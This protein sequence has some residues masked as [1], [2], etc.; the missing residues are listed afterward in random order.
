MEH[1]KKTYLLCICCFYFSVC[2]N[3]QNQ[4]LLHKTYAQRVPLLINFYRDTVGT[5]DAALVFDKINTIKNL[6]KNNNDEDLLLE[7]SLMRATYF[8]YRART[9]VPFILSMLDSLKNEGIQQKKYGSK[10]WLKTWKRC[11]ISIF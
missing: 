8:F 3:A 7:T 5:M 6:A 11:T 2:A 10:Q 9:P 4:Y 1:F